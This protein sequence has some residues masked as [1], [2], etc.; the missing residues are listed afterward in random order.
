LIDCHV[1][2]NVG[3]RKCLQRVTYQVVR[4]YV[5]VEYLHD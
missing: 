5:N 1:L 2:S 4:H 3:T